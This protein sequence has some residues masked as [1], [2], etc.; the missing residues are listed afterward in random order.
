MPPLW[1]VW[2]AAASLS[3][4]AKPALP[5][6]SAPELAQYAPSTAPVTA[7]LIL[8]RFE[9]FD[10]RMTTLSAGFRQFVRWDDS[11]LTQSVEGEL[12]YRKPDRL[13]L[14]YRLPEAQTIVADGTWLWVWRRSTNQVVQ[15]RFEE[16]RK[17]EPAVEALLSFGGYAKLAKNYEVT[18]AS[19]SAPGADG[20]R[21]VTAQ[22]RPREKGAQF[23]L[24]LKFSTR[25]FFPADAELRAGAVS[26]RS[27]F[28]KVRLNPDLPGERFQFTV[29][30]GAD[31]FQNFR[32]PRGG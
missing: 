18:V 27:L 20:H 17:S 4:A 31:V 11:G 2:L 30:K 25:D 8:R 21:L 9:E 13:R 3:A 32:P 1:A 14:E 10:A 22:L 6:P 23:L 24:T 5:A 15:A 28:D 29:P 26:I 7:E 16:W 12:E 19:L